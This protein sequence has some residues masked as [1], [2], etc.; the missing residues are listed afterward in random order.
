MASRYLP[1]AV[2]GIKYI[3]P[4]SNLLSLMRSKR[5]SQS[6]RLYEINS[7]THSNALTIF[8]KISATPIESGLTRRS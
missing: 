7:Q 3:I 8:G 4:F 6:A 5:Y 1:E 2:S